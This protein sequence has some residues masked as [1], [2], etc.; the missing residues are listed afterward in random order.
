MPFSSAF[1]IDQILIT[2]ENGA[3]SPLSDIIIEPCESVA[4]DS[5]GKFSNFTSA[6]IYSALTDLIVEFKSVKNS[7]GLTL[8]GDGTLNHNL[9]ETKIPKVSSWSI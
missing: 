7:D 6:V 5:H 1:D 9:K 3:M 2:F 4:F 8:V